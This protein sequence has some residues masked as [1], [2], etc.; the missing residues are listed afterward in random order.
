MPAIACPLPECDYST[1]DVEAGLAIALLN[2]HA[3]HHSAAPVTSHN[4]AKLE[5]VKRPVISSGGSSED[6]AY[7]ESRWKDYVDAT[8]VT[9]KDKVVQLLEC[10]DEELRKDLTRNAGGSLANKSEKDVLE[11]IK[12]LAVRA[13]N[14][15]VARVHLHNMKQDRDETI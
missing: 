3:H 10:C 12:K 14:A 1:G 9:G 7:F 6:W 4:T 15:M 8:K 5:K 11:A 13:E 2:L